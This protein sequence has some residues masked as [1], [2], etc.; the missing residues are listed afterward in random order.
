MR[1]QLPGGRETRLP[2]L[3]IE[4]DGARPSAGGSLPCAGEHTREVLRE[5]GESEQRELVAKGI[6]GIQVES[7]LVGRAS[8]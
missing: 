8:P 6:V 1:T 5:M 4:M 7:G 3:P 2:I